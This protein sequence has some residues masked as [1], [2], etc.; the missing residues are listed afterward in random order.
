MN[1]KLLLRWFILAILQVVFIF[2]MIALSGCSE[3][4]YLTDSYSLL[5][6]SQNT[7]ATEYSSS[8]RGTPN[9][10]ISDDLIENFSPDGVVYISFDGTSVLIENTEGD[11]TSDD[12]TIT[13]IQA[14]LE[15]ET[16]TG[17][18]IQYK[19][20]EKL[21]YVLSGSYTGTVFIKNKKADAAVVLNGV[22]FRSS[23]GEGPALRFSSE[24]R[25]FIVVPAGTENTII[26]TRVLDQNTIYDDKK[27]SVYAK[28]AL[29]FTG[30]TSST[31]GGSLYIVNSGYKHAVYSKDYI[32][33]A[34]ITFDVS[35]NGT[36]GRDCIRSLNGVII[37]GGT[38]NLTGYGTITDDESVGI[39]VEGEDADEDELTV[40]YTAGA[41]FVIINDGNLT[42]TTVA[43]GITAHW[44][45]SESV[46]S[47]SS[48]HQ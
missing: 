48:K 6:S 28:G 38:I 24:K 16:S 15:D 42:I 35:V 27:G 32:R 18:D 39:K 21:K 3:D 29:I 26:D 9:C 12:I 33:I 36:T 17:V 44:E 37:D 8:S 11:I 40:E 14:S 4:I 20:S 5:L 19:G 10:V 1:R 46:F 23:E 13:E 31:E 2:L 25:T 7:T 30:E 41:G 45:S 22:N 34:D 47:Q 43:K